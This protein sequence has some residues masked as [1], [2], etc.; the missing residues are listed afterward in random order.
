MGLEWS[1]DAP[2]LQNLLPQNSAVLEICHLISKTTRPLST[3]RWHLSAQ[4]ISKC[5]TIQVLDRVDPWLSSWGIAWWA[6]TTANIS[7][8]WKTTSELFFIIECNFSKHCS[9]SIKFDCLRYRSPGWLKLCHTW[10][11]PT[12]VIQSLGTE[13]I[14]GCCLQETPFCLLKLTFW[15]EWKLCVRAYFV[16]SSNFHD[17]SRRE[18]CSDLAGLPCQR[19]F[20]PVQNLVVESTRRKDWWMQRPDVFYRVSRIAG[21][22]Q[23]PASWIKCSAPS[24]CV[25]FFAL[26]K[27]TAL[28][29][30]NSLAI[31]GTW[32]VR[33]VSRIHSKPSWKEPS[34][35][36]RRRRAASIM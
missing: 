29:I 20:L 34:K 3:V 8:I 10:N 9:A 2:P 32:D 33:T 35:L 14:D 16:R 25:M 12:Q 18:H 24:T 6:K 5:C 31:S 7:A 28:A 17:L 15:R 36:W 27:W 19:T 4:R 23:W 13:R 11:L 30:S 22:F 21:G 26:R 1:I